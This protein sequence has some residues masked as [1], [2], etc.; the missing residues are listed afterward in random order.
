MVR[1]GFFLLFIIM[2]ICSCSHPKQLV[3][4]NIENFKLK[5]AGLQ[6]TEVSLDLRL[7][8]PNNYGMKLKDADVDVFINGNRLGKMEVRNLFA[9]PGLDT[10]SMPVILNVDLKSA[11]P[12]VLQLLMKPEVDVKLAGTVKAGRHGLY[13]KVPVNYEGKQDIRAG[14][15]F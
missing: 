9:V 7:F 5:Q 1:T 6:Q 8:N 10:F 2:F 15:K 3:Y 13:V 12:N 4:Q 11:V 14:I